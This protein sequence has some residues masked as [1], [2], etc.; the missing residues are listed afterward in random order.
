MKIAQGLLLR[1]QL[2]EKVQQLKPIR[3]LGDQGLFEPKVKR[4]NVTD[5]TDEVTIN[6]PK[7]ELKDVTAEFDKYSTALR[8]LDA[9]IQQS[10]WT[11][12]VAGFADSENP[13]GE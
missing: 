4:V 3:E 1:K 8:K 2:T 13:F 7:V 5:Q 11:H 10:N 12:D 9:A 6:V